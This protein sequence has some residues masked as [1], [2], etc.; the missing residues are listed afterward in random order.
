VSQSKLYGKF[1][2]KVLSTE[3]PLMGGRLL[4]EVASLPGMLLNW[5]MPSVPYAGLEQ[6]FFALPPEG[7][8]VWVEFEQGNPDKP[9]WSGCYWE[10]GEEPAMPELSPEAPELINVLRSKCCTLIMNDTPEVGG[11]TLSV[12]DP[13]VAVPVTVTMNSE[14]FAVT[15]GPMSLL[16][17]AEAGITIRA[18]EV[19]Q[20][21]DEEAVTVTAPGI[22][23]T[24]EEG[25]DAT[26]ETI[27]MQGDVDVTGPME[28]EGTVGITAAVE[29]GGALAVEGASDFAGEVNV[30]GAVT[31]EGDVNVAGAMEVEGESNV[32]G[33]A[34]FEGDVNIAGAQEVEG[35][36]AVLGI[37]EAIVVPGI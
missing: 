18:A 34:T 33:V 32:L 14:G 5:A 25:I 2:G 17:N 20:T 15:V 7:S 16:I 11:V 30:T 13:A 3:D 21:L 10:V 27:A 1:R 36:V 37:V 8:D 28:V 31:A 4:C 19:V 24:A 26:A 29:I 35:D 23:L 9:I 12:M 6:G 22:K